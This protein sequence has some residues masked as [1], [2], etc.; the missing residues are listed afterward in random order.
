[1]IDLTEIRLICFDVDGTLTAT[2]SG[3]T[4]RE[5][6]DDW[7]WLPGRVEKCLELKQKGVA[8]ALASNQGGVCFSWSN[9][10]EDEIRAEIGKVAQTIGAAF[11]GICC[12]TPNEKALPQYRNPND[13]RR[14]PNPGM[15]LEAIA[16][17]NNSRAHMRRTTSYRGD[18]I[19]LENVLF[20]GDRDE[21]EKA[22]RAAGVRFVWAWEFFEDEH[23]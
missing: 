18:L 9:F 22:A 7:K 4:F 10:T 1:L 19:S 5:T 23:I 20:V 3:A 12:S 13:P 21:D 6:A 11:V 2:K 8:L 14:K 16:Y 17:C 15:I